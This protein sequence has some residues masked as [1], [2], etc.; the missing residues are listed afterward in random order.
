MSRTL[1]QMSEEERKL[2]GMYTRILASNK[3]TDAE[4]KN[5]RIQLDGLEWN[6][7]AGP[8]MEQIVRLKQRLDGIEAQGATMTEDDR[9]AII[10]LRKLSK[11]AEQLTGI[12]QQ[13][14]EMVNALGEMASMG[15]QHHNDNQKGWSKHEKMIVDLTRNLSELHAQVE[16]FIETA[17]E[18]FRK[19]EESINDLVE[20]AVSEAKI[21]IHAEAVAAATAAVSGLLG[22]TPSSEPTSTNEADDKVDF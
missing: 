20:E 19:V 3:S 14:A 7:Q 10:E 18:K 12:N 1:A 21:A 13:V 4:K 8:L 11:D 5:A 9:K 2:H 22:E 16:T 6:N 15:E 17:N